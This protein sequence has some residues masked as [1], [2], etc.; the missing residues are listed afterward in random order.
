MGSI[1]RWFDG[2]PPLPTELVWRIGGEP[3]AAGSWRL[4][5]AACAL[6]HFN[7]PYSETHVWVR[8]L[9]SG[10]VCRGHDG[11]GRL[12]SGIW[13]RNSTQ[14]A[15]VNQDHFWPLSFCP[16]NLLARSILDGQFSKTSSGQP[17]ASNVNPM[18]SLRNYGEAD[19]ILP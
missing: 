6:S 16:G 19:E 3:H 2:P 12:L 14:L 8:A 1:T 10:P 5:T 11:N 15:V 7:A 13:R 9:T 17:R 18:D 4:A